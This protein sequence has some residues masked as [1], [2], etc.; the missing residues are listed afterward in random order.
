MRRESVRSRNIARALRYPAVIFGALVIVLAVL[1]FSKPAAAGEGGFD[2][3]HSYETADAVDETVVAEL[4]SLQDVEV[5]EVVS[6]MSSIDTS[7]RESVYASVSE[8]ESVSQSESL[9]IA[10]EESSIA[11]SEYESYIASS[12]AEASSIAEEQALNAPLAGSHLVARQVSWGLDDTDIPYLRRLFSYCIVIGNSRAKNAVDCGIMTEREVRYMSGAPVEKIWPYAHEIA[13]MYYPKT[14]FIVGLNDIG[15][16]NGSNERFYQDLYGMIKDYKSINPGPVYMM[17]ILPCPEEARPYFYRFFM[18]PDFNARIKQVC[19]E[20]GCIYVSAT[21]YADFKYINSQ[22]HA[23]YGKPFYFLWAQTMASQMHLW[24][25]M[26][27]LGYEIPYSLPVDE[28]GKLLPW[29]AEPTAP[30]EPS[31][32]EAE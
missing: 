28:E 17:E 6:E 8:S 14:L 9:S 19:E 23:H 4:L 13:Y 32:S 16:Y 18:I 24:E 20:L 1:V 29:A 22:D 5:Q 10:M 31:G 25:D 30:E 12:A 2:L 3:P 7:R 15:Y 26:A 27:G 11:Q 21:P